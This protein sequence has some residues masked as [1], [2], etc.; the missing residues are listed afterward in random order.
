MTSPPRSTA[1]KTPHDGE[2]V[3]HLSLAG[4]EEEPAP[5]FGRPLDR[6]AP[7]GMVADRQPRLDACGLSAGGTVTLCLPPSAGYAATPLAAWWIGG[8]G[9]R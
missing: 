6:A 2:R 3:D 1:H 5:R 4:A 9:A 8:G 7:R